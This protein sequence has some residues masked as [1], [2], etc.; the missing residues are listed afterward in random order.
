M[1][2]MLGSSYPRI[3]S[4][5][6]GAVFEVPEQEEVIPSEVTTEPTKVE[7]IEIPPQP[8]NAEHT[9]L[10]DFVAQLRQ[11]DVQGIYSG[12]SAAEEWGVPSLELPH[13][14]RCVESVFAR[15]CA[16]ADPVKN[17]PT[18]TWPR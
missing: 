12:R 18:A 13:N 6:Y 14:I 7:T 4:Q 15:R 17:V 1:L 5:A 11:F 16:V 3:S 10:V 9:Q 2:G 8:L